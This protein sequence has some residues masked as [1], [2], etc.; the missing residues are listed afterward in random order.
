M[1]KFYFNSGVKPWNCSVLHKGDEF[2]RGE[3]HTAFY[4]KNVPK[5][6]NFKF[7]CDDPNMKN[8]YGKTCKSM[9]RRKIYNS[10]MIGKYA[11]FIL[12]PAKL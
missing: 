7:I 3:L 12:Y 5:N 1:Q 10:R 9:I 6:A 4:C 2:I 8:E 11:Y